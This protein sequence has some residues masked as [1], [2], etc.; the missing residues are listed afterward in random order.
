M[1]KTMTNKKRVKKREKGDKIH[2]FKKK[3]M[4]TVQIRKKKIDEEIL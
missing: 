2:S 3:R 4:M 1:T